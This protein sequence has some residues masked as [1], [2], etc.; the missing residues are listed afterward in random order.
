MAVLRFDDADLRSKLQS[1][2]KSYPAGNHCDVLAQ[3][4]GRLLH[5]AGYEVVIV[6]F[7]NEPMP[8]TMTRASFIPAINADGDAFLLAQTGFHDTIRLTVDDTV[9]YLDGL[10]YMHYGATAVT[11]DVYF[12]LFLYADAL[13]VTNVRQV[14]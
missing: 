11:E 2:F 10:V 1:A 6:T 4:L 3:L 8:G 14:E 12:E 5:S 13:D 9:Y 7:Q